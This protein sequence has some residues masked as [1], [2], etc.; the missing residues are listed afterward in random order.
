MQE[1]TSPPKWTK[2][3]T[4]KVYVGHLHHYSNSVPMI[5]DRKTKLVSP[6]FHVMFDGNFD[7]VQAPDPNVKITDTIERLFKTKKYKY[8]HPFGNEHTFLFSHGG[9]DK[10]PYSVSPNIKTCQESITMTSTYNEKNSDTSV[11]SSNENTNNNKAILSMQDLLILHANNIFPQNSKDD[12]KEYTHLHGIY[13]QMHSI[14]KPPKQKAHGRD[15]M[16]CMK[17]NSNSFP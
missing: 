15:Y 2:R 16:T 17:K 6:Q 11:N 12:F 1:G 3:T 13:M 9:V 8:D 5:W 4:Q 10:H 7:T 14:P